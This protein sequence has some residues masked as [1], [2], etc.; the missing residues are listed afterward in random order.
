MNPNSVIWR[1]S[2]RAE[3]PVFPSMAA[4][5]HCGTPWEAYKKT[6]RFQCIHCVQ[7]FR[8][9]LVPDLVSL[10]DE[11]YLSEWLQ[12]LENLSGDGVS[13][14]FRIARNPAQFKGFPNSEAVRTEFPV[15]IQDLLESEENTGRFY[16]EDEDWI[17]WEVL[18]Q[19]L[20]QL[21][22]KIQSSPVFPKLWNSEEFSYSEQY[23]YIN[24]CW[25]NCGEGTKLSVR[26][27]SESAKDFIRD[28]LPL[29]IQVG[30]YSEV[31]PN[32]SGDNSHEF[33]WTLY[34]KNLLKYQKN[35]F[36][37]G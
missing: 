19:D 27:F 10:Q 4:C 17:R 15:Y 36:A 37:Y 30:W 21:R 13:F 32:P 26:L 3:L 12:K 25:T 29:P 22:E 34:L 18:A 5:I 20:G 14:R 24:S 35:S 6:G 11:K 8:K 31:S 7:T 9:F 2:Q 33:Q 16:F 28:L 1:S 23:G